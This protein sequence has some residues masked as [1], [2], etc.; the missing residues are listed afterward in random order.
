MS[1]WLWP[2]LTC[3][4]PVLQLLIS[5][6]CPLALFLYVLSL[7]YLFCF[8]I[9]SCGFLTFTGS[10]FIFCFFLMVLN[11]RPTQT[12]QSSPCPPHVLISGPLFLFQQKHTIRRRTFALRLKCSFCTHS[13]KNLCRLHWP[14]LL[15]SDRLT[16]MTQVFSCDC[17]ECSA[18]I[19]FTLLLII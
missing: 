19:F 2:T 8:H 1:L 17:G 4:W 14:S 7:V 16:R 18:L 15:Q 11:K 12:H 5:P 9:L 3:W 6:P 13:V 10:S